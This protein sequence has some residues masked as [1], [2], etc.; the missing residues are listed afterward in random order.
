MALKEK[1]QIWAGIGGIFLI[2]A[3]GFHFFTTRQLRS[4]LDALVQRWRSDY[5]LNE[6]QAR[7]IRAIEERFHGSGDPFTRSAHTAAENRE[8][9]RRMALEMN[10]EDGAR[11]FRTQEGVNLAR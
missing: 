9:H 11:F 1:L 5:H 10:P 3:S 7:R 2:L 8:H 6:E 4:G